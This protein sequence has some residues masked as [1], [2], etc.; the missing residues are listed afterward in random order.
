ML[1]IEKDCGAIQDSQY[2]PQILKVKPDMAGGNFQETQA[3]SLP[4]EH[5]CTLEI[6]ATEEVA[7]LQ[8]DTSS[9]LGCEYN[10]YSVGNKY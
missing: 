9:E 1:D 2:C 3:P 4:L 10:G 5:M 8:L 7:R 6:D